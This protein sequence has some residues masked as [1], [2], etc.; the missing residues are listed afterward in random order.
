MPLPSPGH[1]CN[2]PLKKPRQRARS[3][4]ISAMP[5][6]RTPSGASEPAPQ[7]VPWQQACTSLLGPQDSLN[8]DEHGA[9]VAQALELVRRFGGER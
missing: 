7:Q 4:P 8:A 1:A 3:K 6:G 2:N 9:P 5:L